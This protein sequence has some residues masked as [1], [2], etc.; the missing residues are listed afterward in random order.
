M[1]YSQSFD[2]TK[3]Q[4]FTDTAFVSDPLQLKQG[5]SYTRRLELNT[6]VVCVEPQT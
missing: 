5:S 3:A 1:K 4:S 6:H 2:W